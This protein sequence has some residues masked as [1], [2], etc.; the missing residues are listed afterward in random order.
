MVKEE[1]NKVSE[2][3][4]FLWRKKCGFGRENGKEKRR[5]IVMELWKVQRVLESPFQLVI[6]KLSTLLLLLWI[7]LTHRQR[8]NENHV[9][10]KMVIKLKYFLFYTKSRKVNVS[11][12]SPQKR[13]RWLNI[14]NFPDFIRNNFTNLALIT[15]L[16]LQ[17]KMWRKPT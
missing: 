5:R 9:Y 16:S 2:N 14:L 12:F 15:W 3:G 11:L 10:K 1:E 6:G 17:N 4:R 8:R 7:H 13:E